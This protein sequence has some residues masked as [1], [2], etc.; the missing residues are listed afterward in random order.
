VAGTLFLSS[1]HLCFSSMAPQ[2]TQHTTPPASPMQRLSSAPAAAAALFSSSS[3]TVAV[4]MIISLDKVT[5]MSESFI[6]RHRALVFTLLDKTQI[7]FAKF[8]G[9]TDAHAQFQQ[10]VRSF[11]CGLFVVA[12][13]CV[14]SPG[15]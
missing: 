12:I 8:V 2:T 1:S 15:H 13:G 6:R 9:S 7:E 10:A 5:T 4:T 14:L 11:M 3:P